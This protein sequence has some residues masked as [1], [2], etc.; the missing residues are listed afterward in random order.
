MSPSPPA[1]AYYTSGGK[2]EEEI[3]DIFLTKDFPPTNGDIYEYLEHCFDV[4]LKQDAELCG[5][6]ERVLETNILCDKVRQ[7]CV[8]LLPNSLPASCQVVK[9]RRNGAHIHHSFSGRIRLTVKNFHVDSIKLHSNLPL[10]K[11][12]LIPWSFHSNKSY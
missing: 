10:A 3:P 7:F 6:E 11:L 1:K 9:I 4:K 8:V 5:G 2:E 12:L